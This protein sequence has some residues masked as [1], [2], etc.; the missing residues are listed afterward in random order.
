MEVLILI[1]FLI[2]KKM[3]NKYFAKI[4]LPASSAAVVFGGH[5]SARV[6]FRLEPPFAAS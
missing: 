4:Q 6:V 1:H 3:S 5:L 2:V